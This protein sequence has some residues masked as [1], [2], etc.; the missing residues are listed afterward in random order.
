[1]FGKY[2]V[3]VSSF[4]LALLVF[5]T[6]V[7]EAKLYRWKDKAGM[8]HF[9]DFPPAEDVTTSDEEPPLPTPAPSKK[10][11]VTAPGHGKEVTQK[12]DTK[13]K[14]PKPAEQ[15]Q[16][17][18]STPT[19][20][21]T[22][23]P[24]PSP[25]P[26][27]AITASAPPVPE[28]QPAA[29]QPQR[30]QPPKHPVKK[31]PVTA[32]K[33]KVSP[34]SK[35]A[36][37]KNFEIISTKYP[38][39]LKIA[40]IVIFLFALFFGYSL[41]RIA[42]LLEVPAVLIA[43]IPVVNF[44]TVVIVSGKPVWW[45]A[46]LIFPLTLP[47]AFTASYMS[48]AENLGLD[49]KAGVVHAAS[50]VF[51][52][53]SFVCIVLLPVSFIL[54]IAESV[55]L[56][57][58]TLAFFLTPEYLIWM[59]GKKRKQ[60]EMFAERFAGGQLPSEK[61]AWDDVSDMSTTDMSAAGAGLT[62]SRGYDFSSIDDT[63]AVY[64]D[65]SDEAVT[66]EQTAQTETA[67]DEETLTINKE[68]LGFEVVEDD[69]EQGV[70]RYDSGEDS[71]LKTDDEEYETITGPG[72]KNAEA[73]EDSLETPV[74]MISSD[75][76]FKLDE[77]G[78]ED[79][80]LSD[81]FDSDLVLETPSD[82]INIENQK[83]Y[84]DAEVDLSSSLEIDLGD[85]PQAEKDEHSDYNEENKEDF[86]IKDEDYDYSDDSTVVLGQDIEDFGIDIDSKKQPQV[87]VEPD[88]ELTLDDE[89]RLSDS[90]VLATDESSTPDLDDIPDL[91]L[92][93]DDEPRLSDSAVLA[94]DESSAPDLE[95]IPD[96][97]LSLEDEPRLSDSAVLA[98]D[99]SSTP[100]LE[101]IPDLELSLDDEPRLSDSAVLAIDESSAPDLED[102]PD[103]GLS[104]DDEPR[105][106]D[107]VVLAIDES[108]APDLD[109]IPDLELSLDDEP[110]LSD[111]AVLATDES[112]TPDFDE[113]TIVPSKLSFENY[114]LSLND[115]TVE[116]LSEESV[117]GVEITPEE[118]TPDISLPAD[119]GIAGIDD[120]STEDTPAEKSNSNRGK[121]K[122]GK[123]PLS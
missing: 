123:K 71:A 84:D 99:E 25:A 41:F 53:I 120:V 34:K 95:D 10:S 37:L 57:L 16:T 94:T 46:L 17:A 22:M 70:L 12:Q 47:Y 1:M 90:A 5:L 96:L 72:I 115:T 50:Y 52:G 117:S 88:L 9:T 73:L 28:Q 69:S 23:A 65:D 80:E 13:A 108:S 38:L 110:G 19:P 63:I 61:R 78:S 91:E 43:L 100:D 112:S 74:D 26:V 102:I 21:P 122:G 116:I 103:L 107:S 113:E 85:E 51:W 35:Y 7:S 2:A 64:N 98:I 75:E 56:L 3:G 54:A 40:P 114:D 79:F 111:S 4:V 55:F 93:L 58:G 87:A 83:P 14:N 45:I 44:Y 49:R 33:V 27:P 18:Q 106:S 109:D 104:L 86:E 24:S 105:L 31:F 29:T 20:T 89:P 77:A 119:L 82:Q 6:A 15:Q 67:E 62:P 42:K 66:L 92:S 36:L 118:M 60:E 81:D 32:G 11:P 59:S 30:I 121:N 48:L 68:D 97:E 39:F 76:E 101:D 8:T